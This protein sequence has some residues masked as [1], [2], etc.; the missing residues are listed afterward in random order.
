MITCSVKKLL[1]RKVLNWPRTSIHQQTLRKSRIS[2]KDILLNRRKMVAL[3]IV[4]LEQEEMQIRSVLCRPPYNTQMGI[5]ANTTPMV[6]QLILRR[7]SRG[8]I[9]IPIYHYHR[10]TRGRCYV[11]FG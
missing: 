4:N 9:R 5:G 7:V 6:N 2:P 1:Q 8:Q 11:R 3:S 10:A